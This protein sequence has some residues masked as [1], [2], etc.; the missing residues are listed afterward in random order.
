[1]ARDS[2]APF[3]LNCLRWLLAAVL[4][5]PFVV[6]D[7]RPAW[8]RLRA[9]WPWVLLM[10][11]LGVG[12]YNALQYLALTTATPI[13][14]SL[15]A[16]SGPIFGLIIGVLLF[17]ERASLAQALGALVSLL[18]VLWVMVHGDFARA[19]TIDLDIGD[20]YM[21]IATLAWAIYTWV[22]RKK[23][24]EV[25]MGVLLFAQIVGG[26]MLALPLAAFE[27]TRPLH[28]FVFDLKFVAM[29]AYIAGGASLVA[30]FCWDR[31]VARVGA[32]LPMF[33]NNLTPVFAALISSVVLA[34][35]PEVYHVVGLCLI[36]LG[37]T[38][39]SRR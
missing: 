34:E 1:M 33:F 25:G 8:P 14:T 22:T 31:G 19:R 18:G 17:G 26:L 30:Y 29:L 6:R 3:H 21:L 36:V 12:S 16:S 39:A 38:L 23:R 9:G 24:P 28:P 13:S 4:L 7:L 20:V 10:G 37:I 2:I 32:Q 15:I 5:F 27:S 11:V 35:S